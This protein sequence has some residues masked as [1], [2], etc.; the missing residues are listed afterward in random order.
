MLGTTIVS[1]LMVVITTLSDW[2]SSIP[3]GYF[4]VLAIATSN[5]LGEVMLI[6]IQQC[7][8]MWLR[9]GILYGVECGCEYT[10]GS[11]FLDWIDGWICQLYSPNCLPNS[12]PLSILW[13][14]IIHSFCSY[15]W[16]INAPTTFCNS[17]CL[18]IPTLM[19]KG[20]K[21]KSIITCHFS[22]NA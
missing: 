13:T 19:W 5:I 12:M 20:T 1:I 3:K 7:S 18:A 10:S 16:S 17:R 8:I 21:G 15:G 2:I 22:H 14:T 11:M 6:R 9:I 4:Q